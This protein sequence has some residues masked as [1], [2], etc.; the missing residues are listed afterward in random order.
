MMATVLFINLK[1]ISLTRGMVEQIWVF[2][3]E[4]VTKMLIMLQASIVSSSA[5]SNLCLGV[6]EMGYV[7][8]IAVFLK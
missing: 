6:K 8:K 2:V 4:I 1:T 3:R 7:E 5:T